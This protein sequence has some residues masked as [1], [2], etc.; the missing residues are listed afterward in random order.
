MI[1]I[2]A[3]AVLAA[4][5]YRYL[6][7]DDMR[8][9]S[10]PPTDA[11]LKDV[12]EHT[13]IFGVLGFGAGVIVALLIGHTCLSAR[14]IV[15]EPTQLTAMHSGEN[16]SGTFLLG[17][18]TSGSYKKFSFYKR[19]EDG[20]VTP[21]EIIASDMVHITEDGA[22]SGVGY[23]TTTVK[24][25]DFFSHPWLKYWA[26]SSRGEWPIRYDFR[27]PAGTVISIF[28]VD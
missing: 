18:G 16:N 14:I 12:R 5:I 21:G 27:V 8:T 11:Y 22:I 6:A 19:N 4:A 20:S 2:F 10:A 3:T 17:S 15:R 23:W 13:F 25:V 1:T 26:I 9:R 7:Y 24:Q 28:K